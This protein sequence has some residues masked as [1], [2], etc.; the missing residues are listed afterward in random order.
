ML[1]DIIGELGAIQA[2]VEDESGLDVPDLLAERLTKIAVYHS[3]VGRIISDI[4]S[5]QDKECED[6]F[7]LY[8]ADIAKMPASI[9]NKFI[10]SKCRETSSVLTWAKNLLSSLSESNA[11]TMT[12]LAYEKEQL[13]MTKTGY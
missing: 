10:R 11:A 5:I 9:S 8:G 6:L 3:R 7:L 13:R 4:E 2:F 1:N 12:R